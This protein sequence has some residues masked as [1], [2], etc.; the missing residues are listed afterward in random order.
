M[1]RAIVIATL[2]AFGLAA[3]EASAHNPRAGKGHHWKAGRAEFRDRMAELNLSDD[4]KERI[5]SVR[6]EHQRERIQSQA[7]LRL[8]RLEFRKLTRAENPDQD[9]IEDQIDRM[10][11]IRAEMMKSRVGQRL[12]V[13]EILTPEQRN[14]LRSGRDG[15]TDEAPPREKDARRM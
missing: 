9:A 12:E 5:A 13:R 15:E 6:E 10:A 1:K 7:D 4:Q 3:L 8:A 11:S 14:Q 2:L